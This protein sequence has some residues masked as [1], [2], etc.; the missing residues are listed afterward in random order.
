ML[1]CI[2]TSRHFLI[3]NF[4]SLFLIYLVIAGLCTYIYYYLVICIL[5][6][7]RRELIKVYDIKSGKLM[8]L[9]IIMATVSE[10]QAPPSHAN[11]QLF[12]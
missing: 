8:I 3:L 11:T 1:Q 6:N 12:I 2:M 7:T 5:I 9:T 10:R 4:L